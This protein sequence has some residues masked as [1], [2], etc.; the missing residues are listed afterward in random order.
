MKI[1]VLVAYKAKTDIRAEFEKL[2]DN[3]FNCCQ[4]CCWDNRMYTPEHAE[5]IKAASAEYGIEVTALWA[6]WSGPK[7]WNFT[8]GPSTLGL[9]PPAYR[10]MRLKEMFEASDF[11]MMLGVTDV[12]THV[13]F[14]P[15]NPRDP[16]FVDT[17][18]ALRSLARLME[19]RGQYFLFETG[20]ETPVTMLRTIE[21]IGTQNI[22]INFDTANLILYGKANSA[23]AISI[24]GK[25]VRNT[26]IKDGFY[27]TTGNA[28]GKQ[29]QIGQGVANLP[30]IMK[31]LFDVGYEGPWIIEREISGPQQLA[32]II[33]SRDVITEIYNSLKGE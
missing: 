26:H 29:V 15:E 17:V 6:G 5:D 24:F 21:A 4:L 18:G 25:Y 27:P 31:R 13:G 33:E 14:L 10:A 16:D 20:Q 7:E 22:G 9:V 8:Y 3:G 1:G 2:R 23:D 12:I 32:D 30:L 19:G 28:L 11:A